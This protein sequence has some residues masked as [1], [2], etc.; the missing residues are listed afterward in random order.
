MGDLFS[1]RQ[2][3]T[4]NHFVKNLNIVKS[5]LPDTEYNKALITYLAIWIDRLL[6]YNTT[7]GIYETGA[8]KVQ[9]IFGRQAISMVFDYPESN[10]FCDSSGSALNMLDWLLRFFDTECSNPFYAKFT[11]A[12]SGDKLQFEKRVLPRL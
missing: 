11:N 12:S 4:I 8:E 7:F 5:E 2:L 3:N 10:P 6:P 9:R 1:E